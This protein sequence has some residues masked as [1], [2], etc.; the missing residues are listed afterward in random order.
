MGDHIPPSSMGPGRTSGPSSLGPGKIG[1]KRLGGPGGKGPNLERGQGLGR[2]P[3]M[4]PKG[5]GVFG[6]VPNVDKDGDPF[7]KRSPN[8]K[9]GNNSFF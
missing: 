9:P 4:I 6:R 7:T 3:S 2:D 1:R 8:K 5:H